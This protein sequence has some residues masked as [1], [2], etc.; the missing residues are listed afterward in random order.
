MRKKTVCL[1][2]MFAVSA[3][4]ITSGAVPGVGTQ[5][6]EAVA[7]P[8]FDLDFAVRACP[9]FVQVMPVFETTTPLSYTAV[10]TVTV[11]GNTAAGPMRQFFKNFRGYDLLTE[12]GPFQWSSPAA[13]STL[14]FENVDWDAI[15]ANPRLEVSWE[16]GLGANPATTPGAAIADIALTRPS[17]T[18]LSRGSGTVA[19]PFLVGNAAELSAMGCYAGEYTNFRLDSDIDLTGT[20]PFVPLGS[21]GNNTSYVFIGSINGAGHT[22]TGMRTGGPGLSYMGFVSRSDLGLLIDRLRFVHAEVRGRE[23]VGVV[24]GYVNLGTAFRR[25]T[26]ESSVVTAQMNAGLVIGRANQSQ[27]IVQSRFAGTVNGRVVEYT[28]DPGDTG[29]RNQ[30]GQYVERVGGIAGFFEEGSI[31][32]VDVDIDVNVTAGDASRSV[33][34]LIGQPDSGVYLRNVNGSIAVDITALETETSSSSSAGLLG[35]D[36]LQEGT[37]LSDSIIT[38]QMVVR[39]PSTSAAVRFRELGAISYGQDGAMHN[40]KLTGSLTVDARFATGAVTIERV[41]GLLGTTGGS[42]GSDSVLSGLDVDMDVVIYGDATDVGVLAGDVKCTGGMLDIVVDGSVVISGNAARVGG[43]IGTQ[44][45]DGSNSTLGN[46][47]DAVIYRG[48]GVTVGAALSDVGATWGTLSATNDPRRA[49]FTNVWWDSNRNGITDPD[50]N[51]PA[52]PATSADLGSYTWLAARGFNMNIWCV[53]GGRPAIIALVSSCDPTVVSAPVGGG[54]TSTSRVAEPVRVGG[55]NRFATA[56]TLSQRFFGPRVPVVYLATAEDFADALAAGPLAGG[57]GPV[58]M[59][60]RNEIP[61]A[62]LAELRRLNPGRVVVLG[63]PAAVSDAVVEAA[64]ATTTGSVTRLFGIDRYATAVAITRT[65]HARGA[66]VVYVATGADFADALGGGPRAMRDGGP[67]LLV[68]RNAIP[69]VTLAELQRLSPDRIVVLGGPDAVSEAVARELRAFAP[70][71]VSRLAGV[72]RYATSV[73]IS[74][75]GFEPGVD[76]VF[77]AN[78]RGY[79]DALP[80]GAAAGGRGPVLLVRE[81]CVPLGVYR[82][83]ERLQAREVIMVGGTAALGD[84]VTSLRRCAS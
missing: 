39:A 45:N 55:V 73:A 28:G 71:G 76:V 60:L 33:G 18:P 53:S 2:T 84:G 36:G 50:A 78:G 59:V 21:Y 52:R 83:L 20:G 37:V 24:A 51:P 65:S 35:G 72:D 3:V 4:L 1:V 16:Y 22:I 54:G 8:V 38:L 30:Q 48:S 14:L 13:L 7:P 61:A 49:P 82:E 29:A 68:Q 57:N 62:T 34:G 80:A 75:A 42:C 56:A 46:V 10:F 26:I 11:S 27:Q 32:D 31:I 5:R 6:A 43:L 79:G 23:F 74:Q 81:D 12:P 58:L 44:R 40:V 70:A 15:G 19:D 64:R 63:G 66:S 41:G 25:I 9:D 47:M 69:A 77:L 17:N 67:I